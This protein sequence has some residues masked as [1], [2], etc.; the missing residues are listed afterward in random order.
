MTEESKPLTRE[1]VIRKIKEHGGTADG[2]DLSGKD[3]RGIDL[4]G[5]ELSGINLQQA[6]LSGAILQQA[7][8]RAANLQEADLDLAD[9]STDTNL[10]YVHWGPKHILGTECKGVFSRAA[11]IYRSLKTWHQQHSIYD[12]AG[13]FH[14]REWVCRRKALWQQFSWYFKWLRPK[15]W[16]KPSLSSLF[17]GLAQYAFSEELFGYGERPWRVVR[18]A[19]I[20]VLGLA[21]AY[22]FLGSFVAGTASFVDALYY[23]A[24]SF[25]A[26]GYGG[27]VPHPEGWAKYMGV[28]QSFIGVF[29]IALFL[30]TFTRK[31]TR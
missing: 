30:V 7:D 15:T 26:L 20:A 10:Q 3:M 25:T 23:S 12:I 11:D 17:Q 6:N 13:E 5:L 27:W 9:L 29:L 24:A 16:L 22:F 4:H 21:L 14:Y 19:A 8:L 31:W 28:A 2:L 1:D 18:A